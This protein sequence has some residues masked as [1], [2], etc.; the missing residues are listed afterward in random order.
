M[1]GEQTDPGIW[2]FGAGALVCG[3]VTVQSQGKVL[4]QLQAA[5]WCLEATWQTFYSK[6]KYLQFLL[7]QTSNLGLRLCGGEGQGM[8]LLRKGKVAQDWGEGGLAKLDRAIR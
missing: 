7:L 4:S 8:K 6:T 2:V 5:G 1:G 3:E